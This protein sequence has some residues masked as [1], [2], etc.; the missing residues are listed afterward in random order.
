[1]ISSVDVGKS[2][3]NIQH[4]AHTCKKLSKLALEVDFLHVIKDMCQK[5][6]TRNVTLGHTL[7]AFPFRTRTGQG[8]SLNPFH[9]LTSHEVAQPEQPDV[10][11][12][13]GVQRGGETSRSYGCTRRKPKGIYKYI[14][15]IIEAIW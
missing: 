6:P 10:K 15:K 12:R 13:K 14:I 8:C 3:D 11:E 9:R 5:Q 1:M 4:P 2:I 7:K